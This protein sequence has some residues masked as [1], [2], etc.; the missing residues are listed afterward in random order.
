VSKDGTTFD[1]AEVIFTA[2]RTSATIEVGIYDIIVVVKGAAGQPIQGAVVQL[3]KNNVPLEPK[4]TTD[5]S[6][7]AIFTKVVGADYAVKA[8]YERFE[9][10]GSLPKKTRSITLTLDLYTVLFGV[11]M[12]FATFLALI[13][14]LI[15]LVIVVAVIVSEYIRWRGRRLGKLDSQLPEDRQQ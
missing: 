13:I 5:S 11:P 15:L 4:L 10:Q 1:P 9:T 3:L 14:G 7:T 12:T 6:G 8:T 2:A